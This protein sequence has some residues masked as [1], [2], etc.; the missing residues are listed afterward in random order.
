[1]QLTEHFCLSFSPPPNS[2]SINSLMKMPKWPNLFLPY[3]SSIH[4]FDLN[5]NVYLS[6]LVEYKPHLKSKIY[7]RLRD[8]KLTFYNLLPCL[9]ADKPWF[10]VSMRD[11]TFSFPFTIDCS[12][13]VPFQQSCKTRELTCESDCMLRP[14]WCQ[15]VFSKIQTWVSKKK[16]S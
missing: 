2:L 5:T 4:T 1:M 16:T 3:S 9:H 13:S 12:T 10:A 7:S 15:A 6:L 11:R 14:T 8:Q